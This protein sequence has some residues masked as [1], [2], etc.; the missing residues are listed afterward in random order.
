[1]ITFFTIPRAFEGRCGIRQTNAIRSWRESVPGCEIILF[2]DDPGVKEFAAEEGCIHIP[3]IYRSPLG[4]PLLDDAFKVTTSQ[5]S[6]ML[7]CFINTDIVLFPSFLKCLDSLPRHFFLA[8]GQRTNAD[9]ETLIDFSAPDWAATVQSFLDNHG[10]LEATCAIDYFLFPKNLFAKIPGFAVGRPKWDNWMVGTAL[11]A[12]MKVIDLTPSVAI[13]HQNHGYTH[14]PQKRDFRWHGPEGDTNEK[15]ASGIN[16]DISDATHELRNGH[17]K[18]KLLWSGLGKRLQ[19]VLTLPQFKTRYG[20]SL[21]FNIIL[22]IVW[23]CERSPG[24]MW[25]RKIVHQLLVRTTRKTT[26]V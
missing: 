2:G 5:S 8:I 1:M 9:F 12:G 7:L 19:Q 21:F 16:C 17:L 25:F 3:N 23:R 22:R 11:N 10:M 15:L 18:D 13:M 14:V 26:H 20:L 4:T 24:K 6:Q